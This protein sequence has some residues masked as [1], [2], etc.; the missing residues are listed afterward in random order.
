MLPYVSCL[1]LLFSWAAVMC[2]SSYSE[3][4]LGGMAVSQPA[5]GEAGTFPLKCI[6]E[7]DDSLAKKRPSQA[8]E[9]MRENERG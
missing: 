4:A 3:R 8:E 5:W 1:P 2:S 6:M 7:R 9:E